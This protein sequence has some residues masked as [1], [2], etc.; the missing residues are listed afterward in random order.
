MTLSA[1]D[2]K[3]LRAALGRRSRAGAE[4]RSSPL[5]RA[6][7]DRA[8]LAAVAAGEEEAPSAKAIRSCASLSRR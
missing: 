8:L 1:D 6:H 4:A 3:L 2:A 5:V 7:P